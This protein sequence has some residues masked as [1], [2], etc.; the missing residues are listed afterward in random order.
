MG[1]IG[2]YIFRTTLG[3]FAMVLVCVTTLMWIT[4]ALR[5]VD[6]MTNQG[7]TILV[8]VALTSLIIPLLVMLIAPIALMIAVAHV[9]NKLG[10]DSELIVMNAAGMRPWQVFRP[11]LAAGMV[12]AVMVAAI[13]FYLSPKSLRD[14][15]RWATQVRAEF[16]ANNITPGR[17]ATIT[18]LTLHV[19]ARE[20]NGQ[21]TGLLIDDRRNPKERVTIVAEKGDMLTNDR[22]VYLLLQNGS[23]QRREAGKRD[24]TL[25]GFTEYAFDLSRVA[26]NAGTIRYSVQE[27]FTRGLLNPP[28]DDPMFIEQPGQFMAELHNRITAPLYPIAFLVVTFAFLGAPRTTRQSRIMS[29]VSAIVVA[30]AI[31]TVGFVGIVAGARAPAALLLPYI[32]LA[33]TFMLGFWAIARG[34]IIEPPALV[35]NAG[36]A[37]I[38]GVLRRS[39]VLLGQ[40]R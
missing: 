31:R 5:N 33:I 6:L 32:A 28:A 37:L 23:A 17:F 36:T 30:A 35:V 14:L 10:N 20:S 2:R 24:P 40:A 38:E 7:Q 13:S 3:A 16:V 27:R 18:Q 39:A 12:V 29:L 34:I 4:Q 1:S 25:V 21:L 19:R 9:L 26:P 22:G 15:R 11:F 8:F